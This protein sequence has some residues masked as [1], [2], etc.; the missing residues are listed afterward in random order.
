[1]TADGG[2]SAFED[3]KRMV[4]LSKSLIEFV[5]N[6]T[7]VS[8]ETVFKVMSSIGRSVHRSAGTAAAAVYFEKPLAQVTAAEA[9]AVL[10]QVA[11][12]GDNPDRVWS[13]WRAALR[14]ALF[15]LEPTIIP[16]NL[17]GLAMASSR[18]LDDGDEQAGM[19]TPTKRGR[20]RRSRSV[21]GSN[22]HLMVEV[23]YTQSLKNVSRGEAITLV[24]GV[25]RIDAT[26]TG[27]KKPEPTM[28][29]AGDHTTLYRIVA[30]IEKAIPVVANKA[31]KAAEAQLR[32]EP[33][34]DF[35]AF[36]RGYLAI[37]RAPAAQKRRR[38]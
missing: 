12:E 7:G 38:R 5:A 32:G 15:L 4:A 20:G 30:G 9:R 1:V 21:N 31:R 3:L 11:G 24:T 28:S 6:D 16:E 25:E 33:D 14:Q 26:P 23:I 27:R 2:K 35:D 17:A 8:P 13:A 18:L 19:F 36:R 37:E 29:R 22:K 34:A 10:E